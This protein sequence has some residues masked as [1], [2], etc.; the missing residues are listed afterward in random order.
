MNKENLL[1]KIKEFNETQSSEGFREIVSLS[2]EY[3]NSVKALAEHFEA[4]ESLV[5]RWARGVARPLPRMQLK[6]V[7]YIKSQFV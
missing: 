1:L 2:I 5:G 4:H 3:E 6:I 7:N